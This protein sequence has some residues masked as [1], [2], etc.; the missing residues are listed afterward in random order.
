VH[1][2]IRGVLVADA[3]RIDA[4]NALDEAIAVGI[5]AT[6]APARAQVLATGE[7]HS[8]R[9]DARAG[10]ERCRAIA[11]EAVAARR[12]LQPRRAAL[13][14]SELPGM[15]ENVFRGTVTATRNRLEGLGSRLALVLRCRHERSWMEA[16]LREAL[17]AG[18]DL[19]LLIAGATVT[20]SPDVVP[21]PSSLP[22]ARSSI[23]AC[24]SSRATCCCWRT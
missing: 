1:A 23:S 9:C 14:M 4:L 17:A 21:L 3:A 13:V 12:A 10:S 22:A 24:R 5:A 8:L 6:H 20:G 11:A 2:S 15:K 7:D 19:L 18:C 16:R